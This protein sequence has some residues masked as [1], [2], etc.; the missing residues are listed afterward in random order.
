MLQKEYAFGSL[1]KVHQKEIRDTIQKRDEELEVSL[2]YEKLWVEI[3]EKVNA[4]MIR[5]YNA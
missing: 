4:N 3:L 1:Y 5:M 2:N